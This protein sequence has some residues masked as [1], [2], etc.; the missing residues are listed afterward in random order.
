MCHPRF[1]KVLGVLSVTRAPVE[2]TTGMLDSSIVP[3]ELVVVPFV[4]LFFSEICR[5]LTAIPCRP[6]VVLG[7]LPDLCETV[8][9]L[10]GNT[11]TV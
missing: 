11:L 4:P 10:K 8:D 5:V 2:P 3:V 7:L 6:V 1:Y 9:I